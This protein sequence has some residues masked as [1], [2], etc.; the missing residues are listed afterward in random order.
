MGLAR[1][2]SK[3]AFL[4]F[5][6]NRSKQY[7]LN[8]SVRAVHRDIQRKRLWFAWK[9]ALGAATGKLEQNITIWRWKRQRD[10][11]KHKH[12]RMLWRTR[13][14]GLF[15]DGQLHPVGLLYSNEPVFHSVALHLHDHHWNSKKRMPVREQAQ[16]GGSGWQREDRQDHIRWQNLQR[17]QIY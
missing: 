10:L 8:A 14:T 7:E 4:H 17:S 6:L 1:P 3:D 16:S 9:E 15:N 12:F 13:R 5:R 2:H 11:A